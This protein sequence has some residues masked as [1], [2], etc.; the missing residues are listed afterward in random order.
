MKR[1][2]LIIPL[3]LLGACSVQQDE[4]NGTTEV[5]VDTEAAENG[6][7]AVANQAATIGG[8]IA[9]DVKETGAKV[10]NE[11]GDVDVDVD[12]NRNGNAN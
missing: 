12:V 11:V 2:A 10:Q 1:T 9:N 4:A 7:E 5:A 8:H 6:A 3:L